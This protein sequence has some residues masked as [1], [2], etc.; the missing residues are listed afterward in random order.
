MSDKDLGKRFPVNRKLKKPPI[1]SSIPLPSPISGRKGANTKLIRRPSSKFTRSAKILRRCKSEPAIL[2]VKENDCLYDRDHRH[3]DLNQPEEEG[4]LFRP[5]T[6]ADVFRSSDYVPLARSPRKSFEWYNKDAKVVVN[7]TVEGSPGPIRT[8]VRLGSSVEDAIHLF[9]QKYSEEGRT[10]KLDK[11][12]SSTYELHHSYFSLQSLDRCN[13]IGD[14]GSRSFY[15]RKGNS[16]S[17]SNE[18]L[19]SG[20]IFDNTGAA[21]NHHPLV[22]LPDIVV[23]KLHK[24]IRRMH[25]LCRFLVCT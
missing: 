16:H 3:P 11:D 21:S 22:L 7:V 19:N 1:S 5:Q 23:G 10:P 9:V 24:F 6:C 4:V 20:H 8:M 14:V 25:K 12:A 13:A 17:S 15:L 2:T 18:S